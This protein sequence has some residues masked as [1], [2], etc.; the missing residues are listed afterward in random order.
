MAYFIVNNSLII[1]QFEN[2]LV[3][4]NN[5]RM[6]VVDLAVEVGACGL[7]FNVSEVRGFEF[8]NPPNVKIWRPVSVP[9]KDGTKV[10]CYIPRRDTKAGKQL[11]ERLQELSRTETEGLQKACGFYDTITVDGVFYHD[12]K[13]EYSKDKKVIIMELPD[14]LVL[15]VKYVIPHDCEL[16]SIQQ[17]Q[18]L[19]E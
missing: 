11:H 17:Y 3:S 14:K 8:N 9:Q 12:P 18:S 13:L 4:V 16:I 2:Y 1:K 7:F 15:S 10:K 19:V 5:K 6:E